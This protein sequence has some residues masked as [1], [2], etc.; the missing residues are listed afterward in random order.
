MVEKYS[1]IVA[2]LVSLQVFVADSATMTGSVM[3]PIDTSGADA[4]QEV[5]IHVALND[6]VP[7]FASYITSSITINLHIIYD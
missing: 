7:H 2:E 3:V 1:V 4:L 6:I 5:M